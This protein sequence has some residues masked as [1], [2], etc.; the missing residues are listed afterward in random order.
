MTMA[1]VDSEQR[2]MSNGCENNGG[3]DTMVE[4]MD[5]STAM[6]NGTSSK[7]PLEFTDGQ[8]SPASLRRRSTRASALK[9]QEK[10][11]LKDDVVA[12]TNPDKGDVDEDGELAPKKR[13]LHD[14]SVFDQFSHKFGLR[15][16]DGNV[17]PL[18]DESE[19]SSLHDS[20]IITL[21][22]SYDKL[23]SKELTPEQRHERT[24][25]IKQC[26]AELRLEEAKLTMLKKV[27]ASQMLA[28]QKLHESKKSAPHVPLNNTSGAYKPLVAPPLNK[29]ASAPANGRSSSSRAN[30]VLGLAGLTTQQQQELLRSAQANPAALQALLMQ[31]AKNGQSP[32]QALAA[33]F[34][35]HASTSAQATS[36]TQ[37][38]KEQRVK[39]EQMLK[40]QAAVNQANTAAQQAKLLAAQ[41]PQQRAATAR[42]AFRMQADKQLMQQI[43]APKAPPIDLFFIPNGSQPDF[44]Y[45]VGLDLVVQRVLKDKNAYRTVSE[46]PY[47][48]E[49]C[50]TDF[51]P[52]WKAIGT[53]SSD[54]HLYCEQC[55]RTAQKR[56][57]RTDHTNVLKKAYNKINSQEKEFEKQI[58]DG[59]LEAAL[60]AAAQAHAAAAAAATSNSA[61][62]AAAAAAS[63]SQAQNL[64]TK[65]HPNPLQATPQRSSTNT[66]TV[67]KAAT[68][69]PPA[70]TPSLP[71]MG[72][73][74][75]STSS[76]PSLK[77]S[78]S[79][80][81]L[82]M[83]A[84]QQQM[85]AMQQLVRANPMMAMAASQ[86]AG[87][88]AAGNPMATMMQQMWNP[89]MLQAAA[90]QMRLQQQ[91]AQQQANQPNMAMSMLAQAVQHAQSSG[92]SAQN[93][94]AIAQLA[95]AAA[96]NPALMNNPQLLRQIQQMQSRGLIES[97]RGKK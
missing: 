82:N 34:A 56:K 3:G 65:S 32:A 19:V 71:K 29:S 90:T 79:A 72:A 13:R 96:I 48:C 75:S 8:L 23:V 24:R 14:G 33:L 86:M 50:G 1:H 17:Y 36:A 21:K 84:M 66:P 39:E 68:P 59:K 4:P 91:Q 6:P 44:C 70:T 69:V 42:Q 15:E 41:T 10:I 38:L 28:N 57:I 87:A 74:S 35:N 77:K 9:A 60:A 85:A 76:T 64:S 80:L 62:A 88:A 55:V 11:K 26:E 22:A 73:P 43:S 37:Q 45:L 20:E 12:T 58:A 7:S 30:P 95:A 54:M 25:M 47:E 49:E 16:Q 92:L 93:N 52:S 51:T 94:T 5:L 40:E 63:T 18:T 2:P 78:N 53:S 46:V 97:L 31:A 81:G 27:K 61:A 83:A 89:M 67:R